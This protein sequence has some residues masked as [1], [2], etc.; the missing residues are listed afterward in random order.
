[1]VPVDAKRNFDEYCSSPQVTMNDSRSK[2]LRQQ[3]IILQSRLMC[4]PSF[5]PPL[6][7]RIRPWDSDFGHIDVYCGGDGLHFAH[8]VELGQELLL[9]RKL[10]SYR[11]REEQQPPPF[12]EADAADRQTGSRAGY[13]LNDGKANWSISAI[14]IASPMRTCNETSSLGAIETCASESMPDHLQYITAVQ[15][16][17]TSPLAPSLQKLR[18]FISSS[19]T[20]SNR[21]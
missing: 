15:R 18:H 19:C 8:A 12:L 4:D 11:D 7:T 16:P 6:G 2:L 13:V 14:A 21:C 3:G 20:D 17:S 1:M 10:T 5:R 9:H